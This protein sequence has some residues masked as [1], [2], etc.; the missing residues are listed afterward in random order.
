MPLLF[1]TDIIEHR[2]ISYTAHLLVPT[3]SV[4]TRRWKNAT[5][6][7]PLIEASKM[8]IFFLILLALMLLIFGYAQLQKGVFKTPSQVAMN[9]EDE[10]ETR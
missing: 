5:H 1:L 8:E 10:L 4:G 6:L 3:L 7:L 2:R 9:E